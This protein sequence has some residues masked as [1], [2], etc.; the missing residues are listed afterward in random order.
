VEGL[1]EWGMP[2]APVIAVRPLA[3]AKEESPASRVRHGA[4]APP[5]SKRSWFSRLVRRG[6]LPARAVSGDVRCRRAPNRGVP[7]AEEADVGLDPG[8]TVLLD[9]FGLVRATLDRNCEH[10]ARERLPVSGAKRRDAV[11]R[12]APS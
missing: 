6:L 1:K 8:F 3:I 4:T 2:L 9:P 7:L 5:V 11:Q 12:G 10:I